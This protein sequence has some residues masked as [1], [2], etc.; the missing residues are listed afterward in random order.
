M[1]TVLG[2]FGFLGKVFKRLSLIVVSSVSAYNLTV[3]E[4]ASSP[5]MRPD[6]DNT[7]RCGRLARQRKQR[8][9]CLQHSLKNSSGYLTKTGRNGVSDLSAFIRR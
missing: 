9:G 1:S 5:D 2:Y 3:F 8:F 6:V 7:S 4:I